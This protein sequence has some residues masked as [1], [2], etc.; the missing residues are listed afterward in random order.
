MA[1]NTPYCAQEL[2]DNQQGVSIATAV[3]H[4]PSD[5]TWLAEIQQQVLPEVSSC[6]SPD[7]A[8]AGLYNLSEILHTAAELAASGIPVVHMSKTG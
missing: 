2:Q 1:M 7:K 5:D 8:K 3:Q 6:V 4:L